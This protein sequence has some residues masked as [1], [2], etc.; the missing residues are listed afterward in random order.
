[1]GV[2]LCSDEAA[3]VHEVNL[4]D[5]ERDAPSLLRE[6]PLLAVESRDKVLAQLHFESRAMNS[7][8]AAR[9]SSSRTH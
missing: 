3:P 4:K 5:E 1:M 9:A 7:R 6:L 8:I 2:N